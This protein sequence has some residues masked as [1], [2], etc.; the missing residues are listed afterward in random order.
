M[1]SIGATTNKVFTAIRDAFPNTAPL[2]AGIIDS[3]SLIL[4]TD[5][6]IKSLLFTTMKKH[7]STA[8]SISCRARFATTSYLAAADL[9]CNFVLSFF[10]TAIALISLGQSSTL[11]FYAKKHITQS[12]IA[13]VTIPFG[14]VCTLFPSL[15]APVLTVGVM[16]GTAVFIKSSSED[17][18][19]AYKKLYETLIETVQSQVSHEE[20]EQINHFI[21][22]DRIQSSADFARLFEEI[23]PFI[24]QMAQHSM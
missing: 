5:A 12:I 3:K 2:S 7:C 8:D 15:S 18:Q 9:T 17:F 14:L 24:Q 11:N 22:P 19:S 23:R 6:T 13:G 16:G 10:F 4:S 20:F 1:M 21:H